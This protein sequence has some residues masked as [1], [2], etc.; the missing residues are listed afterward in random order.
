MEEQVVKNNVDYIDEGLGDDVQDIQQDTGSEIDL[1]GL[2]PE[3]A[4]LD[5]GGEEEKGHEEKTVPL[6]ALKDER[7]KRQMYE[8]QLN[9]LMA[10]HKEV[11]N[12]LKALKSGGNREQESNYDI[13][14]DDV[15]TGADLKK[16]LQA[17][18][19]RLLGETKRQTSTQALISAKQRYEDF[20]EV[21]ALADDL[22]AS[23]PELKG[24]EEYILS[25]PN[26]PFIAYSLG[27][28]HP[29]YQRIV[30]KRRALTQKISQNMETPQ[31]SRRGGTEVS[32]LYEKIK[33]L[34]PLSKEFEELDRRIKARFNE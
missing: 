22:I 20:D 25:Q 18:R 13:N 5:K 3:D 28:L 26:A 24:L 17:E 10:M 12:E 8:R 9:E 34:D 23:M 4:A 16:I 33:S 30:S 2:F 14:D 27:K 1:S 11:L 29:E 7:S 21:V 31:P 19:E 32:D 6:K 15:I